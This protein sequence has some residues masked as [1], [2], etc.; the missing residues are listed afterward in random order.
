MESPAE[1]DPKML[2]WPQARRWL[3]VVS[4]LF[5]FL[6]AAFLVQSA[7]LVRALHRLEAHGGYIYAADAPWLLRHIRGDDDKSCHG[8]HWIPPP[9]SR[10]ALILD[11]Q[12]ALRD[13]CT[14]VF[15]ADPGDEGLAALEDLRCVTDLRVIKASVSDTGLQSL[16]GLVKL[17]SLNLYGCAHVT[18]SGLVHVRGF[19]LLHYVVLSGTAL[20][21]DGLKHLND[22]PLL[23]HLD[24]DRTRVT[25]AGLS[26]LTRFRALRSLD[27]R[28]TAIGDQ[29]IR[30]L[31]GLPL[32]SLK[33]GDTGVTDTG[34]EYLE[35][36]PELTR[37]DLANTAVSDAGLESLRRL[38]KLSDV[39][40]C[41]TRVTGKAARRLLGAG[42]RTCLE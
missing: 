12:Y 3:L 8:L 34:L 23:D 42:V 24:L 13:Q 27:L 19:A 25:D 22:L 10:L 16:H 21:D 37:L 35:K 20:D 41:G 11:H 40:L 32:T 30:A 33:L 38:P 4:S 1:R 31:A 9:P 2:S 5:A 29:G 28:G 36:F 14:V 15:E 17:Q 7:L 39:D 26:H 6:F 18:G